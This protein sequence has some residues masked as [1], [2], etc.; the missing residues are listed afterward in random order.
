MSDYKCHVVGYIITFA[1]RAIFLIGLIGAMMRFITPLTIAP[2]VT[3]I[4]ISLFGAASH[5]AAS[6]WGIAM[7]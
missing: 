7:G 4:G 2:S 1:H 6:H 5:H 3:M